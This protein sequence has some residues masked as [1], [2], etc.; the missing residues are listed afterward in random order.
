[1]C[2]IYHWFGTYNKTK[3]ENLWDKWNCTETRELLRSFLRSRG[4][5][6]LA[7]RIS[8]PLQLAVLY[9]LE[10]FESSHSLNF[11][12]IH[13]KQ[14]WC[15][16]NN[17]QWMTINIKTQVFCLSCCEAAKSTPLPRADPQR[18]AVPC[19]SMKSAP[20]RGLLRK[21]LYWWT[22]IQVHLRTFIILHHKQ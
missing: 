1:M 2:I 8:L 22:Y 6:R 5:C 19:N 18:Q 10:I 15:L 16:C 20:R 14:M 11:V 3:T 21:V 4:F 17:S 12:L 9:F 13:K 7:R